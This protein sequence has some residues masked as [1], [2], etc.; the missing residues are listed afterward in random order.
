MMEQDPD[1]TTGDEAANR[2]T[3]KHPL[4]GR[5]VQDGVQGF[6]DG[7][8]ES[9]GQEIHGLDEGFHARRR[10]SVGIFEAGD[11]GKNL[12][13]TDENVCAGLGGDVDVL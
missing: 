11:G 13:Y 9:V 8:S 4:D 3:D 5:V 10:F 7:G 12:G 2:Q 1:Q 6:R